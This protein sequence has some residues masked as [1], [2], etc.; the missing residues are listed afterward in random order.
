MGNR[1]LLLLS[2][3]FIVGCNNSGSKKDTGAID[4][5]SFTRGEVIYNQK[6]ASCHQPNGEGMANLYPP[7]AQSDYLLENKMNVACIIRNGLSGSITVNGK[8]YTSAMPAVK[9]LTPNKIADVMT[10]IFNSWGNKKGLVT[11]KEVL[12]KLDKCP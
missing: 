2:I 6:C 1:G 3:L 4:N 7:L 9:E 5:Q 12:E 8:K 10:F 11:E